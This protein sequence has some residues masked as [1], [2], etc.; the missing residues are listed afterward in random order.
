[1]GLFSRKNTSKSVS[2]RVSN[3]QKELEAMQA[4]YDELSRREKECSLMIQKLEKKIPQVFE[5]DWKRFE[6]FYAPDMGIE[7]PLEL[8]KQ[9]AQRWGLESSYIDKLPNYKLQL[10]TLEETKY[11]YEHTLLPELRM[12]ETGI[13]IQKAKI[14][15]ADTDDPLMRAFLGLDK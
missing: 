6:E 13:T 2:S 12:T 7:V 15:H 10:E 5:T 1:M 8:E 9:S 3:D 11:Y 14:E 4:K